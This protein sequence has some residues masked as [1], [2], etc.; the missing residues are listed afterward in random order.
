MADAKEPTPEPSRVLVESATV[1]L[2]V[3]LQHTPRAVIAAP[4]SK[5]TEPPQEA[6]LVVMLPAT[7]VVTLGKQGENWN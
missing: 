3:V 2:M 1:G 5:V 7:T 4:P 6:E